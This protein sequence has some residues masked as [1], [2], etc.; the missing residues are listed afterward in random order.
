MVS[1]DVESFMN[2]YAGTVGNAYLWLRLNRAV[3]VYANELIDWPLEL[4][5]EMEMVIKKHKT[6]LI[7]QIIVVPF[8]DFI[9]REFSMQQY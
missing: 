4:W 3:E 6:D 9:I 8:L 5:N 1:L 2:W 7:N